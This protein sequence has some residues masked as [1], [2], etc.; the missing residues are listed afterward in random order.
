MWG[1]RL[2]IPIQVKPICL[3]DNG[4]QRIRSVTR[5]DELG[6]ELTELPAGYVTEGFAKP[7]LPEEG[8][9]GPRKIFSMKRCQES[10]P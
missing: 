6:T 9:P 4:L 10:E 1:D 8:T 3:G 7:G 5:C 2:W